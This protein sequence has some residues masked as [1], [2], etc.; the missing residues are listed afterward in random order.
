M[1]AIFIPQIIPESEIS[2]E[3]RINKDEPKI[4]DKK[5]E[6]GEKIETPEIIEDVKIIDTKIEDEKIENVQKIEEIPRAI[7]IDNSCQEEEN[8]R[9]IFEA[10]A[11]AFQITINPK[12]FNKLDHIIEKLESIPKFQYILVC[13]HEGERRKENKITK[14]IHKHYHIYVQFSQ[15]TTLR[16]DKTIQ[17]AHLEK[18]YSSAQKNI[19]YL[20]CQD[21]NERH[22]HCISKTYYTHGVPKYRGGHISPEDIIEVY[23]EGR[24][25]EM[26]MDYKY[27]RVIREILQDYDRFT[28]NEKFVKS[29]L[30]QKE[31]PMIVNYHVGK[32]GSGK[33]TKVMEKYDE[34]DPSKYVIMSYDDNGF[35]KIL[36]PRN[37]NTVERICINE[38]RDSNIKFKDFLEILQNEHIFNIKNSQKYY[39]NLKY[40]D[41]TTVQLPWEIYPKCCED[42]L[43]IKRRI[44]HLYYWSDKGQCKEVPV[45]ADILDCKNIKLN[46]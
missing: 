2:P 28:M 37:P 15:P 6:N 41:I 43:Q 23:K 7:N 20:K 14:I 3:F 42:R 35:S 38:F 46:M 9:A 25:P 33:T 5:I 32:P 31:K 27:Y 8:K 44:S 30:E 36:E 13:S 40:V 18:A 1:T 16:A 17:F 10:K 29:K 45:I 4:E 24:N 22:K 21:D 11:R 12:L 26:E 19:R 34:M 39:P